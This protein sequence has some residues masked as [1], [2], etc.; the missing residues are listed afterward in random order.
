MKI[1]HLNCGTLCPMALGRSL[2]CHC[3]LLET[4]EGGILIDTGIGLK[5]IK[6]KNK[7]LG[8]QF[9]TLTNPKLDTKECAASQIK[10]FGFIKSDIRHIVLTHLDPDHCGGAADFP[11]AKVHLSQKEKVAY[12]SFALKN[13]WRY[14][15]TQ[16][17]YRPKWQLYEK[18]DGLWQNLKVHKLKIPKAEIYLL[19]LPGHSEGHSGVLLFDQSKNRWLLHAGDSFYLKEE[20]TSPFKFSVLSIAA[21][22]LANKAKHEH[23]IKL[24]K[25]LAGK[26]VDIINSHDPSKFK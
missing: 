2:I 20:I 12:Q 14:Q 22:F 26:K 19:P 11:K 16:M 21:S 4:S 13:L 1:H 8:R 25:S 18:C 23:T 9:L 5:D 3:L 15:S 10:N 17:N 24:L 6:F 7:R